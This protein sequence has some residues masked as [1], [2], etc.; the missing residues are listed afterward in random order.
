MSVLLDALDKLSKQVADPDHVY[1]ISADQAAAVLGALGVCLPAPAPQPVREKPPEPTVNSEWRGQ[2]LWWCI[3]GDWIED[4]ALKNWYVNAKDKY[5]GPV[6]TLK[7][8]K[9]YANRLP[10]NGTAQHE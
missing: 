7:H 9:A 5:T 2:D 6:I 1:A 10:A 4:Q 8:V 3:N